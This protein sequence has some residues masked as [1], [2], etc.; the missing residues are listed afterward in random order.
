LLA[1]RRKRLPEPQQRLGGLGGRFILGRDVEEGFGGIAPALALVEALAEQILRVHGEPVAREFLQE[2]AEAFLGE[3]IV[4]AQEVAV[5]E[6]VSVL[7][8]VGGRERGD[9]CAAGAGIAGRRGV[10]GASAGRRERRVAGERGQIERRA[11]RAA[12]G[13]LLLVTGAAGR[14]AAG[15]RAGAEDARSGRGG[16]VGRGIEG[17]APAAGAG[18]GGRIRLGDRGRAGGRGTRKARFLLQAPQL[19]LELLIAV[20]QLLDDAG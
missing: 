10:V 6:V 4:L 18:A 11:G 17:I 8:A 13:R 12:A 20:L 9:L 15:G 16:G 19:P 5:G 7:R 2:A 14:H 3:R 1:E